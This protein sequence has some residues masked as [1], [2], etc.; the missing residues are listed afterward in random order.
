M[1]I[2]YHDIYRELRIQPEGSKPQLKLH[3]EE[4][5]SQYALCDLLL[6]AE[7]ETGCIVRNNGATV[8]EV[9]LHIGWN[10]V[11][12]KAKQ[13]SGKILE[14]TLSENA[15]LSFGEVYLFH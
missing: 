4:E 3:F 10:R 14:L 2:N 6:R 9:T 15:E 7:K 5:L 8:A 11:H 1:T 13:L 12:T